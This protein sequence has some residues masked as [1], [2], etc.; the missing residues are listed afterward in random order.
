MGGGKSKLLRRLT[1]HYADIAVFS[2]ERTLPVYAT[3]RE[4]IEEHK[5]D[6]RELLAHKVP[7]ATLDCTSEDDE[8]LFLKQTP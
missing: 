2:N 5:G 7:Q 6:L 8:Y 1:Q 3:F 4:L